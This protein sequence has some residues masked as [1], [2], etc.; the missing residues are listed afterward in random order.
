MRKGN[1]GKKIL[2][3]LKGKPVEEIRRYSMKLEEI[4]TGKGRR[5]CE[6]LRELRNWGVRKRGR[7]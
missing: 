1:S 7:K 3:V 6:I 5:K 2:E 4:A